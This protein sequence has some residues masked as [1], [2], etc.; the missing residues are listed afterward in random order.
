MR[1][2]SPRPGLDAAPRAARDF[3]CSWPRSPGPACRAGPGGD[4]RIPGDVVGDH[5]VDPAQQCGRADG[6]GLLAG[7]SVVLPGG[8]VGEPRPSPGCPASLPI[9]P[10]KRPAA[11]RAGRARI[12]RSCRGQRRRSCRAG[13]ARRARPG[14]RG[15]EPGRVAGLGQ[16]GRGPG[17]GQPADRGEPAR[18]PPAP[19]PSGPRHRRAGRGYPASRPV[20]GGRVPARRDGAR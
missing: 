14:P 10:A 19:R 16:D 3:R 11:G 6:P 17:H 8:Q 7:Q 18:V 5:D 20:P 2:G 12:W 15:G 9:P 4:G 1:P 13:R